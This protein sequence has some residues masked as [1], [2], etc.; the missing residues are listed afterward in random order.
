MTTDVRS[1]P[2]SQGITLCRVAHMDAGMPQVGD[3]HGEIALHRGAQE[4]QVP[5]RVD[6]Q[7]DVEVLVF[8]H[9]S[10]FDRGRL[11]RRAGCP[12]AVFQHIRR[13]KC[14]P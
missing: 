5:I 7:L 6:R 10:P 8:H 1:R 11:C 13:Q 3:V 4:F 14:R 9:S 2:S 12:A